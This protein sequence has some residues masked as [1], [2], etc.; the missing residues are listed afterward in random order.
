MGTRIEVGRRIVIAIA[1]VLT[2]PRL[3]DCRSRLMIRQNHPTIDN[4]RLALD[5]LDRFTDLWEEPQLDEV[6]SSNPTVH[7]TERVR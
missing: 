4:P 2:I 1:L 3:Q 7:T 6:S 5:L